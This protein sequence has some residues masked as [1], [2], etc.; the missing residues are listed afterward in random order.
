MATL[1]TDTF[2]RANN[3]DL[4]AAWD[5]YSGANAF[6]ITSNAARP[7]GTAIDNIETYNAVTPPND[8]WAQ[9]VLGTWAGGSNYRNAHAACRFA[10]PNTISGY[11]GSVET[12]NPAGKVYIG[13]FVA[14][15][16]SVLASSA[17]TVASGDVIRLEVVGS[18]LTVFQNGVS[19]TTA[20]DGTRTSGRVGIVSYPDIAITDVDIA[21]FQ[22]GDFLGS[23]AN[24]MHHL[25]QQGIS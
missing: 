23:I 21:S 19:R 2:D 18:N 11:T 14:G 15:V 20:S 7:T 8:Q 4:G 9:I 1:I 25:R 6:S 3:A 5:T 16:F 10:A 12:P 13:E 22:A 17:Q 24:V